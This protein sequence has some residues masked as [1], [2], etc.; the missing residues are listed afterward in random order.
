RTVTYKGLFVAPQL[1]GF[2]AD[3]RDPLFATALAVFH[4]RYSTNTLPNWLLAQ[5]FRMLAHNG[6][7]NTLQGNRNWMRAR[8]ADLASPLWNGSS[9]YL[10]PVIWEDGS[11]SASLDNALELL[12]RSGRDVLHAMMMLAPEAWENMPDMD[13]T[14]RAC[15]EYHAGLME[16]WDGPA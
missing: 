7:I 2:Y 5:P 6:E 13:P 12:E 3:L 15:Y 1:A 4:Q 11:D 8:E 14:L 9:D 10:R 16:P